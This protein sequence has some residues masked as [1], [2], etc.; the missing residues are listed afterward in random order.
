MKKGLLITLISVA[1]VAII[2]VGAVL[3]FQYQKQ[4]KLDDMYAQALACY[5]QGNYD[6][7][8]TGLEKLLTLKDEDTVRRKLADIREERQKV[9]AIK[10]LFQ[11]FKKINESIDAQ[12][13]YLSIK[14]LLA[15]IDSCAQQFEQLDTEEPTDINTFIKEFRTRPTYELFRDD[16]I[17]GK[18]IQDSNLYTVLNIEK[19]IVRDLTD[20]FLELEL[21]GS[22]ILD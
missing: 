16:Y 18:S 10:E 5:D 20:G 15:S 19:G 8:I 22:I 7:A 21:P 14:L 6:G 3:F 11:G 12:W 4:K 2:S 17:T 1:T 9:M 13:D